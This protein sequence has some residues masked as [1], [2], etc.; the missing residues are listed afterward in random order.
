M[1]LIESVNPSP[2]RKAKM[3]IQ[4]MNQL[5]FVQKIK[6]IAAANGRHLTLRAASAITKWMKENQ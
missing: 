5:E 4:I 3:T 1:G 6:D 2:T